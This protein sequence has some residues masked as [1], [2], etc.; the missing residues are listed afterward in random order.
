[1]IRYCGLLDDAMV[2]ETLATY[3]A[4]IFATYFKGECLPATVIESLKAS[5]PVI[6]SNWKYNKE[7]VTDGVEGFVFGNTTEELVQ[8]ILKNCLGR[9]PF[10]EMRMNCYLKSKN[11]EKNK[12]LARLFEMIEEQK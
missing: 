12:C 8:T 1:M 10:Q 3:D 11:Y 5:T 2:I 4:N 6:I 9:N 7:I